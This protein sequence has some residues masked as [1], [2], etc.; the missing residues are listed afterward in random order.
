MKR[1]WKLLVCLL[2]ALFA[3]TAC[4]SKPDPEQ[5]PD[6]TQ[7]IGPTAT[8]TQR[9]TDVPVQQPD[10]GMDEPDL[11]GESIFSANPYDVEFTE[12][13][14]LAEENFFDPELDAPQ[15][16]SVFVTAYPQG[17]EY[18]YAGST[19]IPLNP[20]DMPSPTPRPDLTFTY[21]QYTA[22]TV[23]I[24]FEGPINWQADESQSSLFILTEPASQMKDGQQ[25]VI[26]ISAEPIGSNYD[27]RDLEKHVQ[28]R[29]DTIGGLQFEDFKPSY[30]ATRHMM[31]STGVY[32]NYSGRLT[33]GVEVGGRIQYACIDGV[34][35]GL[36]IAFPQGFRDDFIDV[37]GQVRTSMSRIR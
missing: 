27:Q 28:Q 37:F 7:A 2:C 10:A 24:T 30:T 25:A 1:N 32:A 11:G 29:L 26:T 9:P 15:N 34:L 13:D 33:T 31:G 6:I 8:P 23:G 22:S 21:S 16:Q 17:T 5:F 4:S 35:Y 18:A 12:A 19:P 20:I 36:E 14:V 3:L